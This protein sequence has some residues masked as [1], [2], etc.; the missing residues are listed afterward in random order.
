MKRDIEEGYID[1]GEETYCEKYCNKCS[2]T[3]I[4]ELKSLRRVSAKLD[5]VIESSY[6]G[7][8]ITRNLKST[9]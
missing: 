9:N 4:E 3:I 1:V 5:A 7:I 2:E 8:Y 6:D